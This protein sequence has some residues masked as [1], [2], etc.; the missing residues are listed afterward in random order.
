MVR[1]LSHFLTLCDPMD[2]SMPGLLVLHH[3][4]ELAQ[5][6]VHWVSDAI[7]PSC[8]LSSPSPPAFNL[9]SIRVFYNESAVCITWPKY[10]SFSF[11]VSLSNDSVQSRSRVQLLATP[12]I[13]A[14]QATLSITNSRSS[15]RLTSIKWVMPSLKLPKDPRGVQGKT[16]QLVFYK[17]HNC[18]KP[19][20]WM[21]KMNLLKI[22]LK[23]RTDRKCG[24]TDGMY[25]TGTAA[26]CHLFLWTNLLS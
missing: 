20:R 18:T 9:S 16:H 21:T 6:P 14:R 3:L 1:S 23:K 10:W 8:P 7:Q 12:W 13:A 5:T 4:L 22:W 11:S 19:D 25:K 26:Y 2:C 24:P 15:L 17:S